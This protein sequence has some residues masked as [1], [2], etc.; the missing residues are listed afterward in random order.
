MQILEDFEKVVDRGLPKGSILLLRGVPSSGKTIFCLTLVKE[1][2]EYG[3]R[4]IYVTTELPPDALKK[5]AHSEFGW[6]LSRDEKEGRLLFLDGYSWRLGKTGP[7]VLDLSSLTQ[8]GHALFELFRK[9]SGRFFFVFDSLTSLMLYN[10]PENVTQF[11]QVQVARLRE[12]SAGGI[13]VLEAGVSDQQTINLLSFFVDGLFELAVREE[14]GTLHGY[15]RVFAV[16]SASH[17]KNWMPFS[18][19]DRGFTFSRLS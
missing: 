10:R 3:T 15:F 19:S 4:C 6:D 18:I 9:E 11:M 12:K 13:L 14:Q 7:Y 1:L 17:R 8:V 16:R 2:L 5:Q